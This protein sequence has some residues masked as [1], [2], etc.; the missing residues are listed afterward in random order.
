MTAPRRPIYLAPGLHF[1]GARTRSRTRAS[2]PHA[3]GRPADI[4]AAARARCD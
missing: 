4:A 1:A 3:A 2:V